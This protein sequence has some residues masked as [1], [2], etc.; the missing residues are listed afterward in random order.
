M[1][2]ALTDWL[3]SDAAD[4]S[5]AWPSLARAM[6]RNAA[7]TCSDTPV[8]RNWWSR[9][10]TVPSGGRVVGSLFYFTPLDTT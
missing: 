1:T 6:A 9:H 8:R 7:W 10:C 2:A 5:E 3:S 4:G